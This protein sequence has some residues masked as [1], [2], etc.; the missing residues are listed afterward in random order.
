MLIMTATN[1]GMKNKEFAV[2][3]CRLS[4]RHGH[5]LRDDRL[6]RIQTHETNSLESGGMT[7]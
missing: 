4:Q 1:K 5:D 3:K 6:S 7:R 2:Q